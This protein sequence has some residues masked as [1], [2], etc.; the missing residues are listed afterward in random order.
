MATLD[1]HRAASDQFHKEMGTAADEAIVSFGKVLRYVGGQLKDP[2]KADAE[3]A[4][5]DAVV[6]TA[7]THAEFHEKALDALARAIKVLRK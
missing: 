7:E 2:A 4:A 5:A 3:G 6:R 1:K